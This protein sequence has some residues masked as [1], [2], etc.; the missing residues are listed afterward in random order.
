M[1][2]KKL[3]YFLNCFYL[4]FD[5]QWL[6]RDKIAPLGIDEAFDRQKLSANK[7]QNVR[8]AVSVAYER[9]QAHMKRVVGQVDSDSDN[10]SIAARPCV[11]HKSLLN[12]QVYSDSDSEKSVATCM[13]QNSVL[14]KAGVSES[15]GERGAATSLLQDTVLNKVVLSESDN[16][17]KIKNVLLESKLNESVNSDY[18]SESSEKIREDSESE[19]SIKMPVLHKSVLTC[20]EIINSA[21]DGKNTTSFILHRSAAT[22]QAKNKNSS[23][24]SDSSDTPTLENDSDDTNI[25]TSEN[26]ND[27]NN[28]SASEND[29]DSNNTSSHE[30]DDGCK[31]TSTLEDD[32]ESNNQLEH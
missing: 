28:T 27:S 24:S 20:D 23:N 25:P 31:N 10:D 3:L 9:A 6:P 16:N 15:E 18:E 12:K 17:N 11:L 8:K 13:L 22:L 5:R 32:N 30:N 19:S 14:N 4:F 26:E 21:C 29:S 1:L 2:N 7:R